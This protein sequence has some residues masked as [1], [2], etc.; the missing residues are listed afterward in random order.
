MNIYHSPNINC[1]GEAFFAYFLKKQFP[2]AK[3]LAESYLIAPEYLNS[4]VDKQ[5]LISALEQD[6]KLPI[7]A[8]KH[9]LEY[10]GNVDCPETIKVALN[11]ND[12]SFDCVITTDEN[13]FYWEFHENQHRKLTVSRNSRIYNAENDEV[14]FVPRYIQRL[15]RDV[16]RFQNFDF[17]T[18]VWQDW[19]ISNCYEYE[20]ELIKARN[21]H[22]L[23]H[24]FNFSDFNNF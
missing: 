13:V 20:P 6:K 21:E 9:C 10:L 8:K 16:W 11:P 22:A 18:I 3:Y 19:F 2:H 23:E 15:V 4:F 12:I 24:Q 14:F 17:Y 1:A 7:A 5:L